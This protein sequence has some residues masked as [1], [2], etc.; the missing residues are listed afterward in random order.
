MSKKKTYADE[1]A[2]D[3][4][5]DLIASDSESETGEETGEETVEET[6]EKT[7][8]EKAVI[9]DVIGTVTGCSKLNIRSKPSVNSNVLTEVLMLSELKIDTGNSNEEWF[10]VCTETGIDGYC[11]KKYVSL[12]Q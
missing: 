10:K 4:Q 6:V 5:K 3:K 8:E 1:A 12:K 2:I 7:V 11:M 9:N